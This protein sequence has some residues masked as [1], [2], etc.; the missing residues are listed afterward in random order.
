M[1][2]RTAIRIAAL[3]LTV[4]GVLVVTGASPAEASTLKVRYGPYTIPANGMISNQITSNV[5]RP[6]GHCW[7]TSMTPDLEYSDGSNANVDSGAMLHHFVLFNQ[8]RPDLTCGSNG[9]G[10]LG[11]RFFASGNE[12]TPVK[13]PPGYGYHVGA[14]DRFN[15]LTELMNMDTTS[16]TVYVTVTYTYTYNLQKPVRPVWLD[17]NDCGSSLYSIPKGLSDT[18]WDWAVTMPGD[19]VSIAGHIH[20]EGHGVH[21]T[22]T[23]LPTQQHICTSYPTYGGSPEYIDMMDMPYIS[24]MTS[25]RGNP[26]ISVTRG[27]KIRIDAVYNSP[28][29]R[30]DVMGIM[31]AYIHP[32][33]PTAAI[34]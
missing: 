11:E 25:C 26:V 13:L 27:Q 22:A 12:R 1:T 19:I 21:I 6:C 9:I 15:F 32:S 2:L 24:K 5:A 34:Q 17:I 31:V 3:L 20:T 4:V 16:K 29:A 28:E 10:N 14:N 18:H 8:D 23:V 30:N 33:S 7:I